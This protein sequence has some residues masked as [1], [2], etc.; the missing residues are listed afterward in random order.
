MKLLVM[1]F[2]LV[3]SSSLAYAHSDKGTKVECSQTI[4]ITGHHCNDK[5]K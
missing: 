5:D 4:L 2:L 3:L 1:S